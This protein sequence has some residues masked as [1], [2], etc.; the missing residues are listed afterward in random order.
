MKPF[1]SIDMKKIVWIVFNNNGAL[2]ALY[3]CKNDKLVMKPELA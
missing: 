3:Q 2:Q 1:K